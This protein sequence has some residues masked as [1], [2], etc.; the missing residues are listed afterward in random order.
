M[1][2]GT[3]IFLVI[4]VCV[5]AGCNEQRQQQAG[6]ISG[7]FEEV[8]NI[9]ITQNGGKPVKPSEVSQSAA[10]NWSYRRDRFGTVMQTQDIDFEQIDQ[11]IRSTYGEPDKA[12]LTAEQTQQWAIFA[13]TAGV[14]I[15]YSALEKGVR[16]TILKPVN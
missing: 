13:K 6:N 1:K 14:S 10:W 15:W 8:L 4:F 2:L 16:V 11:F 7:R 9:E 5:L 12:G 3:I